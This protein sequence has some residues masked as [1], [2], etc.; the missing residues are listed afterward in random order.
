MFSV[1]F[2][3]FNVLPRLSSRSSKDAPLELRFTT[4]AAAAVV[5]VL[6][7]KDMVASAAVGTGTRKE[8]V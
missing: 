4:V 1:V 8:I 2:H 3:G 6:R 5:T 7:A